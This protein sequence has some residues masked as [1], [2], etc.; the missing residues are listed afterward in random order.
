M[1]ET[2][3]EHE[4][5]GCSAA[6]REKQSLAR[7]S[8][9]VCQTV[10]NIYLSSYLDYLDFVMPQSLFLRSLNFLAF[11]MNLISNGKAVSISYRKRGSQRGALNSYNGDF[12][13]ECTSYAKAYQLDRNV[14]NFFVCHVF[15]IG[16]RYIS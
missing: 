14:Y 9:E 4:R 5:R 11:R 10:Q 7:K 15:R 13:F 6:A 8:T 1:D 16:S 12:Y 2:P 3:Q